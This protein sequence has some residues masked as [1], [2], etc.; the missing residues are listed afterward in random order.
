MPDPTPESDQIPPGLTAALRDAE[1]DRPPVPEA[2]D[3]AILDQARAHFAQRP[4]E[5]PPAQ[6]P[7]AQR[8]PAPAGGN[9]TPYR[10]PRR[11]WWAAPLAAAAVIVLSLFAVQTVRWISDF[12]DA[13]REPVTLGPGSPVELAWDAD[14]SG[15]LDIL[16]VMILARQHEAGAKHVTPDILDDLTQRIVAL[17]K[18]AAKLPGIREGS[19]LT[20]V[21]LDRRQ[22]E[23][24]RS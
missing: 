21:R 16:D 3:R 12:G 13:A 8:P 9:G 19:L 6:R 15:R 20:L 22:N 14:R 4:I 7:P 1:G 11:L 23:G 17:D 24:R 2:V 18:V 5:R 10:F